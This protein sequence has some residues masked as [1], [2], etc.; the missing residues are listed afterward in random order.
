MANCAISTCQES[1]KIKNKSRQFH[2]FPNDVGYLRLW[3]KVVGG[4]F[5]AKPSSKI[6]SDHF[7]LS[8]YTLRTQLLKLTGSCRVLKDD[9]V[10]TLALGNALQPTDRDNRS[11]TRKR[12]ALVEEILEGHGKRQSLMDQDKDNYENYQ[13]QRPQSP[14]Q[15][16]TA[17][18][19]QTMLVKC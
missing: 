4:G 6:C 18:A 19:S 12:K 5:R 11:V 3:E 13:P 14:N 16:S 9:A 2:R 17:T 10:P 15:S 1:S 7:D 8:A